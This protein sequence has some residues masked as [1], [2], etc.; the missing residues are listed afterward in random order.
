MADLFNCFWVTHGNTCYVS[1][2]LLQ[3]MSLNPLVATLF[4]DVNF[5]VVWTDGNLCRKNNDNKNS[6][7]TDN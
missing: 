1:I 2:V 4:V 5:M 3:F 7:L 6:R